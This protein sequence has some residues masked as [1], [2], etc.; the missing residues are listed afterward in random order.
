MLGLRSR[1]AH[2]HVH[3]RRRSTCF[4]VRLC[5]VHSQSNLPFQNFLSFRGSERGTSDIF[6]APPQKRLTDLVRSSCCVPGYSGAR[7]S[8]KS[9]SPRKPVRMEDMECGICGFMGTEP[10][11]HEHM[12][13]EHAVRPVYECGHCGFL[14]WCLFDK[15]SHEESMHTG[16]GGVPARECIQCGDMFSSATDLNQHLR[17]KH[18]PAQPIMCRYCGRLCRGGDEVEAHVASE[19]AQDIFLYCRRKDGGE[20]VCEAFFMTPLAMEDHVRAAHRGENDGVGDGAGLG[21]GLVGDDELDVALGTRD[22]GKMQEGRAGNNGRETGDKRPQTR[23]RKAVVKS[24]PSPLEC[25]VCGLLTQSIS[26][27]SAHV[28]ALHRTTAAPSIVLS[29]TASVAPD[30][31]TALIPDSYLGSVPRTTEGKTSKR[32]MRT[33]KRTTMKRWSPELHAIFIAHI[34]KHGMNDPTLQDFQTAHAPERSMASLRSRAH[35]FG[36][37]VRGFR[38]SSKV[39]PAKTKISKKEKK[40]KKKSSVTSNP[41]LPLVQPSPPAVHLSSAPTPSFV[42]TDAVVLPSVAAPSSYPEALTLVHPSSAPT[43]ALAATDAVVLNSSASRAADR[44]DPIPV[45]TVSTPAPDD[46]P[47]SMSDVPSFVHL[48]GASEAT[49]FTAPTASSAAAV[50][51]FARPTRIPIHSNSPEAPKSS[52]PLITTYGQSD[53]PT[54]DGLA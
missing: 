6:A 7:G 24:S 22:I 53:I 17:D 5:K 18:A 50:T 12:D 42:A 54:G 11:S 46:V 13:H 34:E 44:G 37:S 10:A 35:I 3:V 30:A 39:K 27:L 16:A 26:S 21:V 41:L 4:G 32:T 49:I 40:A 23:G 38:E 33:S 1:A 20:G 15:Q 47:A 36:Y 45:E 51:S 25:V 28:D 48:P 9:L 52:P 31:Q 29:L 8:G 43:P 19:H 2:L 14:F